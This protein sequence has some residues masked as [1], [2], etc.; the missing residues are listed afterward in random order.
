MLYYFHIIDKNLFFFQ[1]FNIFSYLSFFL[2]L[3]NRTLK[4]FILF[5]YTKYSLNQYNSQKE[6]ILRI[7]FQREVG[8]LHPKLI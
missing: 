6:I 5:N 4:K 7:S 2:C 8:I 1:F 3:Y